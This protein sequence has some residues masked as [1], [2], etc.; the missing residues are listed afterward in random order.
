[1]VVLTVKRS[2]VDQFIYECS[3][4]DS[5]DAV[6]RAV[7]SALEQTLDIRV[8]NCDDL[9]RKRFRCDPSRWAQFEILNWID[10][11]NPW[12]TAFLFA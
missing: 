6:T 7:V 4:A 9:A 11:V 5:A 8:V 10:F 2:E 1:M 3:V 12:P